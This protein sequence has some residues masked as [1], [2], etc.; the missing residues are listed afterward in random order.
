MQRKIVFSPA[1]GVHGLDIQFQLIGE[2]EGITF[3]LYTNW[4]LPHVQK[5]FDE[6][7]SRGKS[8]YLFHKPQPGGIGGHWR[9]SRYEGQSAIEHCDITGGECYCCGS[10]PSDDV[11]NVL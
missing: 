9:T 8:P 11:F 10:G 6:R 5:E 2:G 4:M 1:F 3:T 7:S